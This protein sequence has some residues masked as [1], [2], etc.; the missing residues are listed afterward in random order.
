MSSENYSTEYDVCVI[1][2][3]FSG[4]TAARK[5][6]A[7]GKRVLILDARER[8]GGRGFTK[9]AKDGTPVDVGGQW[10]GPTQ[11]RLLSLLE[12]L[13]VGTYKQYTEGNNLLHIHGKLKQF[14]GAIPKVGPAALLDLQRLIWKVNGLAKSIDS[15]QPWLS[16]NAPQQ[17]AQSVA[18]WMQQHVYSKSAAS[19]LTIAVNAVFAAEPEELSFLYFLQYVKSAGGLEALIE[20]E[21][22]AQDS[23]VIGGMG[24]LATTLAEK[25]VSAGVTLVTNA[26]VSKVLAMADQVRILTKDSMYAADRVIVA[27]SPSDAS[28]I[29]WSPALPI[30]RQ[31]LMQN[32]PMGSAIKI[33]SIYPTPFWR[34]QGLS[35]E[36]VTDTG[37]LR[38]SFDVTPP[39]INQQAPSSGALVGFILGNQAREWSDRPAAE[40]QLAVLKQ[41]TGYFG[42]AALSPIDYIEKDWCADEWTKGCYVGLMPAGVMSQYGAQLRPA[43]GRI[44]WAGTETATEW[45][46]Y[47]DGAI[48]AGER[49]AEE[50]LALEQ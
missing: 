3:G 19:L 21:N 40:R 25:A 27:M 23:R 28:G 11:L 20:A 16:P 32:M 4:L 39:S 18:G 46:G 43:C 50:V 42:E 6:A 26:A 35:G 33:I 34:E 2:A 29:E 14:K 31:R 48:Q 38:M 12:E 44:H 13:G 45:A 8:V 24:N 5:L 17:D 9:Q 47:F 15:E 22:G 36:M 10:V 7:A 1:G 30:K 49:A 41:L 37:P